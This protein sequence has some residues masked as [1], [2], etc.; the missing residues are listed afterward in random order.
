LSE[1][2]KLRQRYGFGIRELM[3]VWKGDP[4]R[5]L[6]TL[7][8]FNERLT[9]AGGDRAAILISPPEDFYLP[10]MFDNYVRSIKSCLVPGNVRFFFNKNE[11][12]KNRLREFR[13]DDPAVMAIGGLIHSL[14]STCTWMDQ[15]QE[16][17]FNVERAYA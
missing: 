1:C 11:I 4:D 17:V 13:R 2:L 6:T 5:F 9:I 15:V 10:K 7:A 14:L 16:T 12:L 8:L 3:R